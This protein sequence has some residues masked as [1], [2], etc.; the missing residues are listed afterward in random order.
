MAEEPLE[1]A[2]VVGKTLDQ[3]V[4]EFGWNR[5]VAGTR[6]T[7]REDSSQPGALVGSPSRIGL[8]LAS[9]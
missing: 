5:G 4:T 6:P 3:A 8:H 9:R 2:Q 1:A 7:G